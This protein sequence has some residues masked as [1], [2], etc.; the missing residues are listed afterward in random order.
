MRYYS[1]ALLLLNVDW[2]ILIAFFCFQQ[3]RDS[4]SLHR[5]QFLLSISEPRL[6]R[7][8]IL[9]LPACSASEADLPRRDPEQFAREN[10]DDGECNCRLFEYIFIEIYI[11]SV[12]S[13]T[14]FYI[15]I[16]CVCKKT[17][18]RHA[19]IVFRYLI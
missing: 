7:P 10:R 4:T 15:C 16:C 11:P 8:L 13:I 3:Q 17:Y 19:Y 14:F 6:R 5:R 1:C 18:I 2:I 12:F 9:R